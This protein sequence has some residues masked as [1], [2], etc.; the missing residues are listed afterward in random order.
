M[1]FMIYMHPLMKFV[2]IV[3]RSVYMVHLGSP[4]CVTVSWLGHRYLSRGPTWQ[5]DTVDAERDHFELLE[6]FTIQH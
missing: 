2:E 1:T 3:L 5:G 4:V 6:T